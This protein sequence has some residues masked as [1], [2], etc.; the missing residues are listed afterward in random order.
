MRRRLALAVS[1]LA[2]V[3]L[4]AVAAPE[5]SPSFLGKSARQWARELTGPDYGGQHRARRALRRGGGAAVPT[6]L[7]IVEAD[8]ELAARAALRVALRRLRAAAGK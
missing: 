3:S 5:E 6:L 8:E 4:P 1:L 7:S 2:L